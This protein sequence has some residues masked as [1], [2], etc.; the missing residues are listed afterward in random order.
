[1]TGART[2]RERTGE[3]G[4]ALLLVMW[5][6]MVLGVLSLDFARYMRD[7]GQAAINFEEETIGY[8]V[9]LAGM[10]RVIYEA[11]V[12]RD[13]LLT[14]PVTNADAERRPG[15][16][17]E[18]DDEDARVPADGQWHDGE[19]AGRRYS[20]RL[21]DE[22]GR[23][24]LNKA[25]E[26]LL[27]H[28]VRSLYQG[29]NATTGLDKRA[30]DSIAEI[31]DAIQDWRDVDDVTHLH[32]AENEYY[33]GL[34][35]PYPAKNGF[36][37]SPEEL[38][39]VKGITPELF[40][41]H[42]GVPGLRDIFTV[43]SRAS[44]VNVRTAPPAVLQVILNVDAA[45]VTDLLAEREA[46]GEGFLALVQAQATTIDPRL[47]ALLVDQEPAIVTIDAR[48]DTKLDTNLSRVQV[49]ADLSSEEAEGAKVIR[50]LDRA[51]WEGGL[52][53]GDA[54]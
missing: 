12:A 47:A 11:Q 43:Y 6:F 14:T 19:F 3:R 35:N 49:V 32:G 9:A 53:G 51:P 27:T 54:S 42:D 2:T 38:L 16:D 36:F 25:D 4:I 20:V 29:F 37:D 41:G 8:Y 52:P 34:K 26:T 17:R 15:R 46:A 13:Q 21:T 5:I 23:I 28:V 1:V 24:A 31:V 44:T 48:A 18:D 39:L 7:D 45:T 30:S 10:N 50:W 33:L 22:G 40:Y